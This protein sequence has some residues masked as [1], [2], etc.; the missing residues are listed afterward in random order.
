MAVEVYTRAGYTSR[1][2]DCSITDGG[3]S[4]TSIVA[5]ASGMLYLGVNDDVVNDNSGQFTVTISW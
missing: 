3:V 4:H 5:P 1:S 2:S